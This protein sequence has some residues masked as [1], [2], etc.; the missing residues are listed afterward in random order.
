MKNDNVIILA[1]AVLAGL[2][3]KAGKVNG[4]NKGLY[5]CQNALLKVVLKGRKE[6][7]EEES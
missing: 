7:E 4:Y 1:G 3:Y 5:E 2:A 6:E